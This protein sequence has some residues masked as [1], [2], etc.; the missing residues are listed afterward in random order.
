MKMT[1]INGLEDGD[2]NVQLEKS[3]KEL[4][5]LRV[6]ASTESLDNPRAI[7]DLKKSIARLLTE[8]RRREMVKDNES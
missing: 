3:R 6:K 4:F 7:P 5:D 8:K 2:L 1:E